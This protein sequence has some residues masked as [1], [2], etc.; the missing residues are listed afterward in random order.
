[1]KE[2]GTIDL[3]M[4]GEA[5]VLACSEGEGIR[6]AGTI[7]RDL[8]LFQDHFPDFPVVPGVLSLELMKKAAEAWWQ[9]RPG[10]S[11]TT[12][13]LREV[14]SAKYAA[15]LK[16]GDAWEVKLSFQT[17]GLERISC[18]AKLL[19]DGRT[20]VSAALIFECIKLRQA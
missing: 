15:Y 5:A 10:T 3:G 19:H 1:M 16:P 14:E 11:G 4:L 2:A 12:L 20:A 13:R 17:D 6:A 7:P 18:G 9:L 8:E